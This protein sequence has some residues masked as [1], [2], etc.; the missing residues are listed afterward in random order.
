M[1]EACVIGWPISHSRSPLIHGYWLKQHGID[2]HY[3]KQAVTP[4][5]L[6][7]FISSLR[8]GQRVGANVTLPHK[9]AALQFVDE[10]DD[11]ARRIGALNTIWREDEKLHATSTDGA[12]FLAN[13]RQT[14]P[15]FA[16]ENAPVTILGAGGS[17]R[18]IVDE[19]L[20]TG[21]DRV[22]IHNR[23]ISRAE[24]LA[25]HFGSRV[26]ALADNELRT[27]LT[28]AGLLVN[29]TSAG[30]N[31]EGEL[32]IPWDKLSDRAVVADIVYT[33]LLTPFL[34]TARSRGHAIVP[35]LGMLLHQAVVGFEKWF[36]VFPA[37]T[38]DLHDLV[39]RDIDPDYQP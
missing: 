6:Q 29:T 7:D 10:A 14:V 26:R 2:G 32:A 24:A 31:T 15:D 39:A 4:A 1:I 22:S 23:T 17:A 18:A 12:G 28:E 27:A 3:S 33:P 9:E 5:G 25:D 38:K 20:R 8:H 37:V 11:R 34:V 35:G 13:L 19:L 30:M 36:G 21:V 16:V